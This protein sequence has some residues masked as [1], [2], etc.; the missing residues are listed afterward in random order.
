M[1]FDKA[2][3]VQILSESS[4]Q[5]IEILNPAVE[6]KLHIKKVKVAET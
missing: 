1:A 4:R 5:I 3:E 2:T 6:D